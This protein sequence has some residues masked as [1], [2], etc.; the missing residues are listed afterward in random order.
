MKEVTK[1]TKALEL[2]E[3]LLADILSGKYSYGMK[4]NEAELAQ[5]FGVSRTPIREAFKHL[6]ASGFVSVVP[7]KGVIVSGLDP[8]KIWEMFEAMAEM[9][10]I[11]AQLS[12]QKMNPLE[13]EK[14]HQHHIYC[15]Q[16]V[17]KCD[18]ET[19]HNL[20]MEFHSLIFKGS[21]N[22]FLSELAFNL[23]SRLSPYRRLQFL[24]AGR[25]GVSFD[26]HDEIV[27]AILENSPTEAKKKMRQ[28]II[29]SG[30]SFAAYWEANQS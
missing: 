10:A 23:R 9:E 11:C 16:Q 24:N 30:M 22:S 13:K 14:L 3:L 18:L 8:E 20:N 27:T 5:R 4:L 19:Y 2:Q 28:H 21:H 6:A 1:I 26:E 17:K 29:N 12:S 25:V 15:K 7:H